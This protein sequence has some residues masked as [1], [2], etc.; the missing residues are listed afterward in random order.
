MV[1]AIIAVFAGIVMPVYGTAREQARTTACLSNTRQIASGLL[2]YA[3]DY[4]EALIPWCT[5]R[6]TDPLD[7]QIAGAWTTTVQ[8]YIK[9]R[10]VLF[11][12]SFNPDKTAQAIDNPECDGN[13]TPG[14]GSAGFIPAAQYLSHYGITI[15]LTFGTCVPVDP[16]GYFEG[17]GWADA[18]YPGLGDGAT[19]AFYTASLSSVMSLARTA[20]SGDSLTVVRSDA[21]AVGTLFGCEGRYRH[22]DSG[23]T[24]TFMDGH[25]RYLPGNPERYLDQDES[26]CWYERYFTANR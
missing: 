21:P 26:G 20:Y 23:A 18:W 24:F 3:Q 4:D 19:K 17:S 10:Q 7:Q 2:L 5:A 13:G 15:K 14:S 6:D 1:I 16:Y 22:K 9:N 12:P 25:A 11:C 8:P